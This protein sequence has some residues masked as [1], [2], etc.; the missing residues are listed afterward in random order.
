M[1]HLDIP[2]PRFGCGPHISW[3]QSRQGL[4]LAVMASEDRWL[5]CRK[6]YRT[7]LISPV[8]FY[9][10]RGGAFGRNRIKNTGV[11]C[12]VSRDVYYCFFRIKVENLWFSPFLLDFLFITSKRDFYQFFYLLY[13]CYMKFSSIYQLK[14]LKKEPSPLAR[15]RK[16]LFCVAF[17]IVTV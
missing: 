11:F 17:A 5:L 6:T 4:N 16:I 9:N 3:W 8:I 2:K 12:L 15:L 14:T 13:Y 7:R 10:F 1:Q